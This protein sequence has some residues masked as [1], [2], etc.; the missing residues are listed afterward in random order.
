MLTFVLAPF[1]LGR[2]CWRGG[3]RDHVIA[4]QA[5]PSPPG[6]ATVKGEC[7]GVGASERSAAP[8]P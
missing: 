1:S 3:G 6:A 8:L 4:C 7:D 5:I 2:S